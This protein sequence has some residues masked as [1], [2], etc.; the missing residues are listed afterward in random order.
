[1]LMKIH[2]LLTTNHK[3][4]ALKLVSTI[5]NIHHP[6][7]KNKTTKKDMQSERKACEKKCRLKRHKKYQLPRRSFQLMLEFIYLFIYFS[8]IQLLCVHAVLLLVISEFVNLYIFSLL[9]LLCCLYYII[10]LYVAF[11]LIHFYS[12]YR[13][14]R[15]LNK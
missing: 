1:M 5:K 2:K 4:I 3:T 9:L 15:F 8:L 13:Y 14:L 7:H 12:H 10:L 6:S 11:Q